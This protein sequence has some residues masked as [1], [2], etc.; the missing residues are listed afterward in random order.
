MPSNFVSGLRRAWRNGENTFN[1][2]RKEQGI[3][4]SVVLVT[5]YPVNQITNA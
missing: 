2:N 4:K 5:V 1:I 3:G